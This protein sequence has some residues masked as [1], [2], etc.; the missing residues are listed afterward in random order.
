MQPRQ[1]LTVASRYTFAWRK[2]YLSSFLSLL[3]M[4][5]MVLAIALLILVLSVMNGFDREMRDH[6]LAL[7]PQ[8]T[9]KS[10]QPIDDWRDHADL[11]RRHPEVRAVA[12]FVELQ[13]MLVKDNN[14]DTALLHG[15]SLAEERHMAGLA[16]V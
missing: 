15:I 16:R 11:L 5:G 9:I 6:I 3:S 12:P 4:L 7:V 8:L 2:G 14:I 1:L 10:W 13:G